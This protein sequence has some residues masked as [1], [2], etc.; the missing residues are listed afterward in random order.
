MQKRITFSLLI[1]AFGITTL[2][3][4]QAVY[5]AQII[6]Q[7]EI[8][9]SLYPEPK[10]DTLRIEITQ[11]TY[12]KEQFWYGSPFRS[13]SIFLG[14]DSTLNHYR[15]R[16]YLDYKLDKLREA[17]ITTDD[18]D[19]AELQ[20]YSWRALSGITNAIKIYPVVEPWRAVDVDWANQPDVANWNVD[21]EIPPRNEWKSLNI[22]DIIKAQLNGSLP[23]NG[24]TIHR[25]NEYETADYYCSLEGL[26]GLSPD[27]CTADLAPHILVHIKSKPI[28]ILEKPNINIGKIDENSISIN[29]N[30]SETD[31][32]KWQLQYVF[33]ENDF[34]TAISVYPEATSATL[35]DLSVNKYYFR[36]RGI[37]GENMSNWSEVVMGE[38]KATD[39]EKPQ[40]E[41]TPE[42]ASPKAEIKG[43][44]DEQLHHK[45][46]VQ[47]AIQQVTKPEAETK[48]TLQ[49]FDLTPQKIKGIK[50]EVEVE[51]DQTTH[52]AFKYNYTDKTIKTL[53]CNLPTP[54]ITEI[55]NTQIDKH[56]WGV[57]F[58]INQPHRILTM[59]QYV[60]CKKKNFWDPITWFGCR[61][62]KINK[63]EYSQEV[64]Y[65][66]IMRIKGK[67]YPTYHM[68]ETEKDNYD[69]Y[70]DV[71]TDLHGKN[72]QIFSLTIFSMKLDQ[73]EWLD[74]NRAT[75]LSINKIVPKA[76]VAFDQI[77]PEDNKPFRF[78]FNK[79]INVTQWH[80]FTAFQ[81][82]HTGI[83][84]A[85]KN[86]NIYAPGDGVIET[87]TWDT[88]GKKCNSGGNVMRIRHT[89]GMHSVYMHLTKDYNGEI[90]RLAVGDKVKKGQLIGQTGNSGEYNCQPLG[91]HL[92]FELR[93][94]R[95]QSTH[96]DPVPY[97]SANWDKI[98]TVNSAGIPGRLSGD[99]PHPGY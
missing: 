99:N 1:I 85:A 20:L 79:L 3:L 50:Q 5:A 35:E 39:E 30:S 98:I 24:I 23:E 66:F 41:V 71:P 96:V 8:R 15:T 54:I 75:N 89:N 56:E 68:I 22:T 87:K 37:I 4:P 12:A 11:D 77:T 93:K 78:V 53:W 33:G 88:Y 27:K 6:S 31:I 10:A 9:Y 34:N 95:L 47:P 76:K 61:E 2:I 16:P 13:R 65:S 29:W 97:V 82:P 14:L 32:E 55:R 28:R 80:G 40:E 19:S 51:E 43:I 38:I 67:N 59:V 64:N 42:I 63:E 52:C 73:E 91:Y 81:S 57:G 60:K 7:A 62:E 86:E 25:V 21:E 45:S 49:N 72:A 69:M 92:H 58:K 36:V 84:F 44:K 17:G 26:N 46:L 70:F 18:I 74:F 94:G 90:T 48:N 83:D